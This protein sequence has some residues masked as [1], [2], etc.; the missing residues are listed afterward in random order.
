MWR[1][2]GH[3]NSRTEPQFQDYYSDYGGQNP[4]YSSPLDD[5]TTYQDLR[6]CPNGI[7]EYMR[8]QLNSS[9]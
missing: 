5:P 9:Q 2:V 1:S 4:Y 6:G 7:G 3:A 8:Y